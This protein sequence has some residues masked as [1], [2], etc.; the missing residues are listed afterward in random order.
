MYL[1]VCWIDDSKIVSV[2]DFVYN[3]GIVCLCFIYVIL[4]KYIKLFNLLMKG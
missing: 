2:I 1:V 3:I 4:E